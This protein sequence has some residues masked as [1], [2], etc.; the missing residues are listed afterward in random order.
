MNE[1]EVI[2][3]KPGDTLSE[4]AA[5]HG[6]SLDELQR[7]NGVEDPDLLQVGQRIVVCTGAD[8]HDC[9]VSGNA[10]YQTAAGSGEVAGSWEVELG[11]VIVLAFLLFL[12]RLKRGLSHARETRSSRDRLSLTADTASETKR[13]GLAA[14]LFA[15]LHPRHARA[16]SVNAGAIQLM[17][18]SRS[19]DISLGNVEAVDVAGGSL[20]SSLR[21]R[22]TTGN[23][24]VSGLP[25][26]DAAAFA[27]ALEAARC[28]W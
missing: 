8:T 18:G 10:V 23:A 28:E 21:I 2:Q 11:S 1:I 13:K 6:V 5:R 14:F 4:I 17:F 26:T 3:V 16:A 19:A 27:D 20:F 9:S 25:R 22:H 15:I 7:W 12:F 24:H